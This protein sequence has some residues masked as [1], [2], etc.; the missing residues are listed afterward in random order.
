MTQAFFFP[1]ELGGVGSPFLLTIEEW[2]KFADY[3]NTCVTAPTSLEQVR[4]RI[5][6]IMDGKYK[7][8]WDKLEQS[9]SF[10][11]MIAEAVQINIDVKNHSQFWDRN[12]HKGMI[13][14][15]QN[16]VHYAELINTSYHLDLQK[17]IQESTQGSLSSQTKQRFIQI[18]EDLSTRS[19]AFN[20]QARNVVEE[21]LAFYN[22]IKKCEARLE[23]CKKW[24]PRIPIQNADQYSVVHNTF[25]YCVGPIIK[26]VIQKNAILPVLQK[27]DNI[28]DALGY[29]LNEIA[30]L[31]KEGASNSDELIAALELELS[32]ASWKIIQKEAE[33][34]YKNLNQL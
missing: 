9:N 21:L 11:S 30:Q 31:I 27:V 28:W 5:Y 3:L 18:C 29:D 33:A 32:L 8:S 7:E 15:A 22:E 14:L 13:A 1:K 4:E 17:V 16:I 6:R 23:E 2:R 10:R 24:I 19:Q 34:F 25:T 12:G 26:I 20:K